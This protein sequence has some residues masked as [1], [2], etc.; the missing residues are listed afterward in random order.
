M[1][2]C[3]GLGVRSLAAGCSAAVGLAGGAG[4]AGGGGAAARAAGGVDFVGGQ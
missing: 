2:Q 3:E 4:G 1:A